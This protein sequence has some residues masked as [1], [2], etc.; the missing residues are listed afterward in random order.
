MSPLIFNRMAMKAKREL[1]LGGGRKTAADR[2]ANLKHDP[3]AEYRDSVTRNKGDGCAT[4]LAIPSPSFK[5][6]MMTAA[7]DLPGTKR[8][9]IGRL[10]WVT[11]YQVDLYGVPELFMSVVRNSDINHTPDIRTRAI[12]P[13]WACMV[14]VRFVQP[15]LTGKA[16]GN[17][18]AA[19]GIIAGVGD[20]RQE[21]GK[22]SC[23][24]FRTAS[25]DDAEFLDIVA[26]GGR[27]VQDA[28]LAEFRFHDAETE[29][30]MAFYEAEVVRRGREKAVAGAV[31]MAP[32][33][34]KKSRRGQPVA[35]DALG[36]LGG[37]VVAQPAS[38]EDWTGEF[39]GLPA[40]ASSHEGVAEPKPIF[41]PAWKANG[42][43]AK[44]GR[45]R[46]RRGEGAVS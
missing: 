16:I 30:L 7:L 10:V 37:T 45:G 9:E 18:M 33:S 43:V 35:D 41:D 44:R 20:F 17:L 2:A 6:A 22:G 23:G 21:K 3:V 11:G 4:R 13:R 27:E 14:T 32:D 25:L 12:V 34:R 15:K 40:A 38:P 36:G 5:G 1:L 24:Q 46:P 26:G 39:A 29:E 8:T 31:T 42:A 28:A 19:A